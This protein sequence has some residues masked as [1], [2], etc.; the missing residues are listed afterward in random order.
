[1]PPTKPKHYFWMVYED[2]DMNIV[3]ASG[4]RHFNQKDAIT[5]ASDSARSSPG[6]TFIVGQVVAEKS[7]FVPV[8]PVV[9]E[10]S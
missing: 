6:K 1:M 3:L 8:K 5:E 2:T 9:L 7:V 4:T 10:M